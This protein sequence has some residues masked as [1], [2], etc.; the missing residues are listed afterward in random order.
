MLQKQTINIKI[1]TNELFHEPMPTVPT[2]IH[3]HKVLDAK[4]D[5]SMREE[6]ARVTWRVGARP[7]RGA[8]VMSSPLIYE[9]TR[10][11]PSQTNELIK[12]SNRSLYR[13]GAP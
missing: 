3:G 2:Q 4:R 10:R 6:H 11:S 1:E 13:L 12:T 9:Y 5:R 8:S 7:E